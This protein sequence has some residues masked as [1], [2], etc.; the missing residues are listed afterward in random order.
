MGMSKQML[1]A[2][3]AMAAAGLMGGAAQAQAPAG[4]DPKLT[5]AYDEMNC[6]Y[7]GLTDE[8]AEMIFENYLNMDDKMT[9][10]ID[11]A[12]DALQTSCGDTYGWT[13]GQHNLAEVI[14]RF[15]SMVDIALLDLEAAGM[16]NGDAMFDLWDS[17]PA[18][19]LQ[20]LTDPDWVKDKTL[21]SRLKD[22]LVAAGVPN[23]D[24]SLESA[25]VALEA[26]TLANAAVRGW[27]TDKGL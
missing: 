3:A 7:D 11:A 22:S 9:K 2:M 26:L 19:D 15:G 18:S 1:A 10:Q 20:K 14:G 21:G 16:K 23:D 5:A 6:I 17:L 25:L 27:L 12:V 8:Q 4:Q 24:Q 13:K